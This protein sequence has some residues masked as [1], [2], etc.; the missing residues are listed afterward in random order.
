MAWETEASARTSASPAA[1]WAIWA[2]AARWADWNPQLERAEFDTE[3]A[4]GTEVKMKIRRGGTIRSTVAALEPERLLRIE[5]RFPFARLGHEHRVDPA[6]S[7]SEISNRTYLTG[8]LSGLYALMMG[9][10]ARKQVAE[11]PERERE[12]AERRG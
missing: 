2:D 8:P 10:Q 3:L 6:G 4:V 1:V 5:S 12:L 7:G 11:L 9:R